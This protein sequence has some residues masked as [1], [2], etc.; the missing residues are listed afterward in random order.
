MDM[1]L[2]NILPTNIYLKWFNP[3]EDENKGINVYLHIKDI[4]NSTTYT[5]KFKSNVTRY[6]V[7]TF[8]KNIHDLVP[9]VSNEN[10]DYELNDNSIYSDDN[11]NY[12]NSLTNNDILRNLCNNLFEFYSL[13]ELNIALEKMN[14]FVKNQYIFLGE[15][16]I[17]VNHNQDENNKLWYTHFYKNKKFNNREE[18]ECI[19]CICNKLSYVFDD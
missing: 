15:T 7:V 9:S 14:I 6:D 8:L 19:A 10:K 11:Y 1:F 18:S 13:D 16:S 5:L 3:I 4:E 2:K 17:V 12:D